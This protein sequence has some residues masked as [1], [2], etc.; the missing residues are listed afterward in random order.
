MTGIDL[1]IEAF[2]IRHRGFAILVDNRGNVLQIDLPGRSIQKQIFPV[3][4]AIQWVL[5]Q[6]SL[7]L[8]KSNFKERLKTQRHVSRYG[9]NFSYLNLISPRLKGRVDFQCCEAD[10][11]ARSQLDSAERYH[12]IRAANILNR[13]YFNDSQLLAGIR[14]LKAR[15]CDRGLL[16]INRTNEYGANNATV[17]RLNEGGELLAVGRL[18]KGS[19]I[20]HLALTGVPGTTS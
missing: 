14:N 17:F 16:I 5:K 15:L 11:I 8:L 6:I 7:L 4:N 10:F 18:G 9:L 2:L 3:T 20:E 1:T 19:E 13:S 12:I